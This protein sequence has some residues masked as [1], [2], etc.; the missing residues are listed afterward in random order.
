MRSI[1]F[2][3]VGVPGVPPAFLFAIAQVQSH[4]KSIK[5]RHAVL[6][7]HHAAGGEPEDGFAA[8]KA[9]SPNRSRTLAGR[10]GERRDWD[11]VNAEILFQAFTI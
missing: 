7:S 10:Q 8:R 5:N 2:R 11:I 4:L 3:G 9:P 1:N 6:L